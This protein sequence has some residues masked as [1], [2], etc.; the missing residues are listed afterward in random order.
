MRESSRGK[1]EADGIPNRK[2]VDLLTN[3]L[4]H[5]D[6]IINVA[7]TMTL[8]GFVAG[9]PAINIAYCLGSRKSGRYPMEDYYRSRHYEDVV[10]EGGVPLAYDSTS[11]FR[12]VEAF[13]NQEHLDLSRQ[14]RVL[15]KKCKHYADASAR[16]EATLRSY[17]LE[18]VS[19]ARRP[20]FRAGLRRLMTASGLS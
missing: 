5:A 3:Q 6:L 2:D 4:C 13:L 1:K 20:V 10:T 8:E 19:N 16:I 18:E 9:T 15:T 12:E 11:L 7:S 17:A 14:Q